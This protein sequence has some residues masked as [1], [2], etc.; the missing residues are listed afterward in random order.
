MDNRAK[1]REKELINLIYCLYR[2]DSFLQCCGFGLIAARGRWFEAPLLSARIEASCPRWLVCILLRSTHHTKS[3]MSFS[4]SLPESLETKRLHIRVA[5][6]GDGAVFNEAIRESVDALAPW[7]AW[8]TPLPTPEQSELGCRKAYARY[9]LNEDLMAFFFLKENN[10]L[11]GGSGIHNPNWNSRCFEVG[12]WGRSSHSGRGLMQE[13][14]NALVEHALTTMGANR[15]FLTTD[16][17]NERS[18]RLA[19]KIG[20]QLEGT[21]RKDRLNLEGVPRNTRVYARIKP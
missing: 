10:A 13:G 4:N 1:S 21:L 5:R 16:E 15:V 3:N 20:F 6:P 19:E 17:R 12:Y 8:V 7:L 11:I 9:L 18:L 14:V 2:G